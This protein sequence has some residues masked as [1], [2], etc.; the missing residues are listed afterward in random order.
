MDIQRQNE[1]LKKMLKEEEEINMCPVK[2]IPLS[3]IKKSSERL[4]ND[5]KRREFLRNNQNLAGDKSARSFKPHKKNILEKQIL[6][7][8]EQLQ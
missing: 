4:F 5:A 1:K 7:I 6:F 8:K 2:K 3:R